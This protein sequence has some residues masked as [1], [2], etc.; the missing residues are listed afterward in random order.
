MALNRIW[1]NKGKKIVILDTSAILTLFEFSIDLEDELTRLLGSYE[2]IIPSAVLSELK[3]LSESG[4]GN[5]KIKSKAALKLIEK[6]KIFNIDAKNADDS[7][8]LLA[9][10]LNGFVFTNDGELKNR[11]KKISLP[12]IYLRSKQK[13]VIE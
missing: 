9:K 11:I 13:L 3:L 1:A 8:F 12:V 4:K 7:V 6:Y 5:K 10:K 2:I